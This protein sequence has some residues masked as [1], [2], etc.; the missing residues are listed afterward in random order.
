[1]VTEAFE[2]FVAFIF[3]AVQGNLHEKMVAL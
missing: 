1:L 2:E 3:T